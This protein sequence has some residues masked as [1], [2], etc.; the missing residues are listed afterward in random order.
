MCKVLKISRSS[1]YYKAKERKEEKVLVTE[2]VEIFRRSRN[3]YGTRKIKSKLS[4]RNRTVSRRR[5]SRIMKHE[6][7]VSS[8]TKAK[9]RTKKDTCNDSK[10]ENK[11]D[12]QFSKQPYRNIVVSDLT[13]VSEFLRLLPIIVKR[14]ND[15]QSEL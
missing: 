11:L 3:N 5:I 8:Y 2:I 9:Y 7:L 14:A 13:G 6:G 12:R 15:L 1:Y 10:I 4:E